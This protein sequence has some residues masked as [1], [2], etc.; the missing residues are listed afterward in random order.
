MRASIPLAVSS[1]HDVLISRDLK[2]MHTQDSAPVPIFQ[3]L[4]VS[5]LLMVLCTLPNGLLFL[6]TPLQENRKLLED[7]VRIQ[8]ESRRVYEEHRLAQE[9]M[10][11]SL[12]QMKEML[13]GFMS[14]P[15]GMS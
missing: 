14:R 11:G 7:N 4:D 1:F 6:T 9:D 15:P 3:S 8:E 5:K 13:V 10:K 2:S 12:A